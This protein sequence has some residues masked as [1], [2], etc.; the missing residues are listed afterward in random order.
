MRVTDT[1]HKMPGDPYVRRSFS[2][3]PLRRGRSLDQRL[4]ARAPGVLHALTRRA[5]RLPLRSRLRN[6]LIDQA[7]RSGFD[8]Y[9]RRDWD[10]VLAAYDPN[11]EIVLHH[12]QQMEAIRH[13]HDGWRHYWHEWFDV[14]D[15]S[16]ME[17]TEIVELSDRLLLLGSTR[18]RNHRG[19]TLEEPSAWLLTMENGRIVRHEEWWD[20]AAALSAV[21][22]AP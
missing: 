2:L 11:V 8:A 10:V 19:L 7:T 5:L 15:E 16:H 1:A 9:N 20:H 17:P 13:G 14:W 3:G 21:E 4:R 12:V 18:C 6:V 22:I